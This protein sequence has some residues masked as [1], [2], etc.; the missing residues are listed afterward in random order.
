MAFALVFQALQPCQREVTSRPLTSRSPSFAPTDS[1][2]EPTIYTVGHS[3][4]AAGAFVSLL[5]G[6]EIALL[7]DVRSRSVSK[8]APHFAKAALTQMLAAHAIDYEFLGHELGGRP[9][10]AEFYRPDGGV[11]YARRA[12]APDFKDGI[13]RL[14]SFARER[15]TAILCA[16]EDPMR[17]HRRLLVAPALR[18]AG[19]AVVHIRGDGRLEPDDGSTAAS[20]QLGLFR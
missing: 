6:H 17:C 18:R 3:R 5:R 10:G 19:A 15:R 14:V 8:W 20:S 4:H 12:E 9:E 1:A 2:E 7:A 11:D 16:E 13:E